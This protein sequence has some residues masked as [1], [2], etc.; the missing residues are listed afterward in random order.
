MKRALSLVLSLILMLVFINANL[1]SCIGSQST[2]KDGITVEPGAPLA[3][4]DSAKSCGKEVIEKLLT[5][6]Y[7]ANQVTPAVH[8]IAAEAERLLALTLEIEIGDKKYIAFTELLGQRGTELILALS[9]PDGDT[10]NT[11]ID[12]Y[13]EFSSLIS[14]EYSGNLL[15]GL[16]LFA[17]DE[18]YSDYYTKYEATGKASYKVLADD[19]SKQ[20]QDFAASID[21]TD[22]STLCELVFFVRG[23]F[24]S[25]AL[26][27]G[28]IGSLL[29]AEILMIL[30]RFDF[31]GL[32]IAPRGYSLLIDYYAD[33][34]MMRDET[35]YFDELLYEANYNG[36]AER[37]SESMAEVISLLSA[38]KDSLTAE[39]IG[40]IR[41]GDVGGMLSAAFSRFG[42]AE[43]EKISKISLAFEK[44]SSYLRVGEKFFGEEFTLYRDTH[45]AKT[46]DELRLSVGTDEFYS[47]LEGYVYGISPAFSYGMSNDRD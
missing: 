3:V 4:S 35:T 7:E 17:Y 44:K 12:A 8:E 16:A 46:L 5:D 42:D 10:V 31:S 29:D 23:L 21:K 43:Y 27:T 47:C 6:Y 37:I 32:D 1:A 14:S 45:E 33:T 28:A 13:L 15:Y 26:D 19:V 38:V 40:L 25:G 36:D 24:V 41:A 39:D 30:E 34:L 9:E 2:V 18:K 22:F 20:K 11:L